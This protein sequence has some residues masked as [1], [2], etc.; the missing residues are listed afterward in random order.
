MALA[1]QRSG[2]AAFASLAAFLRFGETHK[3]SHRDGRQPNPLRERALEE[4]A[5]PGQPVCAHARFQ[6]PPATHP[7][8]LPAA[9]GV[10]ASI[11]R[12]SRRFATNSLD[13][14]VDQKRV[15]WQQK[16]R[17]RLCENCGERDFVVETLRKRKEELR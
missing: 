1:R 6:F 15:I 7:R 13:D 14:T 5:M 12:Q 10:T 16:N 2:S 4:A 9:T 3:C 8:E 17:P 11:V